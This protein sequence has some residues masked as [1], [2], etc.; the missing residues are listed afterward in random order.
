MIC[1]KINKYYIVPTNSWL[2]PL[3]N[4]ITEGLIIVAEDIKKEKVIVKITVGYKPIIIKINKL[5]KNAPNFIETKY[6]Q[7]EG[8]CVGNESDGSIVT[9][10]IMKKYKNGSLNKY[11][12]SFSLEI[13]TSIL[14][15][16]MLAQ[17]HAFYNFGFLHNDIHLG[18]ILLSKSENTLNYSFSKINVNLNVV[19]IPILSDFGESKLFTEEYFKDKNQFIREY[20]SHHNLTQNLIDTFKICLLLLDDEEIK[21][22]IQ[23]KYNKDNQIID[24]KLFITKKNIRSIY[25]D[26]YEYERFI[27]KSTGLSISL[28]NMFYRY[29]R[30]TSIEDELIS[31]LS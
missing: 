7:K 23:I 10:E 25:K 6:N 27:E 16:L 15:Q 5:L 24:D 12:K 14:S 26:Y 20:Y 17:L 29:F 4:L 11:E 19:Y 2:K 31:Q 1:P 3:E 21:K 9:L 22:N 28:V 13:V 30:N 8:F 18:N